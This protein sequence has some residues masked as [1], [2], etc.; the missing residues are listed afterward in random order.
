M[1]LYRHTPSG[2]SL[3]HW[4]AQLRT[5]GVHC[6]EPAGAG[7]V[8]FKVVTKTG[9]AFVSHGPVDVRLSFPTPTNGTKGACF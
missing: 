5:D 2:Q 7:P 4:V 8:V 3:V 1:Y 9:A 6:Q